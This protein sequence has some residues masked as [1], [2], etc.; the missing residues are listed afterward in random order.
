[1]N[2]KK[3]CFITLKDPKPNLKNN[4]KVN[5]ISRSKYIFGKEQDDKYYFQLYNWTYFTKSLLN[6]AKNE[7]GQISKNIIDRI[8]H[9]LRDSLR[10]NQWKDTSEVT[11]CFTK[12]PDKNRYTCAIFDIKDFSSSIS[13]KLLTNVLNFAKETTDVSREDLQIMYQ[14]WKSLLFSNEKPC[15]KLKGNLF[16]VTMGIYDGTKICELIDIFMLN[17]ISE[18]CNKDDAGLYRDD[19]LAYS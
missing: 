11:E 17:K 9:Q 16:E 12:I 13:E 15:M 5:N 4:P 14:A 2:G 18:K 19:G 7:I 10:I 3:E 6:P 8:N 1:M